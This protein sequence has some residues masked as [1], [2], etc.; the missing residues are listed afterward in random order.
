MHENSD[1]NR[2]NYLMITS[3]KSYF[4]DFSVRG[5]ARINC[6]P[7]HFTST[8]TAEFTGF[9]VDMTRCQHTVLQFMSVLPAGK[10]HAW[11]LESG[12]DFNLGS[13]KYVFWDRKGDYTS[14]GIYSL[15]Y[16]NSNREGYL[17]K[18]STL[19]YGPQKLL[20]FDD[21]MHKKYKNNYWYQ[22]QSGAKCDIGS[23][24]GFICRAKEHLSIVIGCKHS[25][26]WSLF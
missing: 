18:F 11:T 17:I 2:V 4:H 24:V 21:E 19:L 3:D 12:P 25:H 20:H 13:E 16:I 5:I 9:R 10:V 22:M 15:S 8:G 1:A 26:S 7:I 14:R 6:T 23:E